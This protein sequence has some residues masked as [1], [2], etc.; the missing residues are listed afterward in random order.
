MRLNL[1]L[2][3][4]AIDDEVAVK[5]TSIW[6]GELINFNIHFKNQMK[7]KLIYKRQGTTVMKHFH[8]LF[9]TETLNKLGRRKNIDTFPT[10]ISI[11]LV[12]WPAF[13]YSV[14]TCSLKITFHAFVG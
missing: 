1:T 13:T 11:T 9:L 7:Y 4:K 10:S 5:S 2:M 12:T 3:N 14:C 8:E 6:S